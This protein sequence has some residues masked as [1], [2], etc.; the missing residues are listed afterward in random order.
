MVG[1]PVGCNSFGDLADLFVWNMGTE[2]GRIDV[3]RN[4]YMK[5]SSTG[6]TCTRRKLSINHMRRLVNSR[7]IPL[8]IKWASFLAVVDTKKICYQMNR[9]HPTNVSW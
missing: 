6:G 2:Y 5:L 9:H 1:K 3:V 7:L 8:P 4:R